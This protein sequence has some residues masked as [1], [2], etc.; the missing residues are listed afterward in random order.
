MRRLVAAPGVAK[1]LL[2]F[3]GEYL[4]TEDVLHVSKDPVIFKAWD[5]ALLSEMKAETDR[6]LERA[7]WQDGKLETLLTAR[8]SS[9]SKKLADHYGLGAQVPA[10]ATVGKEITLPAERMGFLTQ[11]TFLA[12]RAHPDGT[13]PVR[14]GKFV[15][16]RLLCQVLPAPPMNADVMPLKSSATQQRREQLIEHS[17]RAECSTCHALMDP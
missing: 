10:G 17:R 7:L 1:G 16:E 11:G 13:D 12:A 6:L 14:R 5:D 9:V 4:E 3:L 2:R 8:V 15:R